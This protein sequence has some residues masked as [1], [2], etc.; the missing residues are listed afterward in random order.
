MGED[1][2]RLMVSRVVRDFL[3]YRCADA[4]ERRLEVLSCEL[5]LIVPRGR[6]EFGS[7]QCLDYSSR[8]ASIPVSERRLERRAYVSRALPSFRY[9]DGSGRL[10]PE[11]TKSALRA[12]ESSSSVGATMDQLPNQLQ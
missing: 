12:A 6:E 3:G 10:P 1:D 5:S 2:V 8:S 9:A 11:R 4:V 7:I